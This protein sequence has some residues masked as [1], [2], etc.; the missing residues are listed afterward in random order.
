MRLKV[1]EQKQAPKQVAVY[2]ARCVG[3]RTLSAEL[4]DW[5]L[6]TVVRDVHVRGRCEE[7]MT[8]HSNCLTWLLE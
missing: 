2:V 5:M 6:E 1:I 4:K 7:V 3:F 8:T